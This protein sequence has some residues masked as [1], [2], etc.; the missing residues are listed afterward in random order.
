MGA[1]KSNEDGRFRPLAIE[2][3]DIVI[4]L[5]K[6]TS[7]VGNIKLGI[8]LKGQRILSSV[9]GDESVS[10]LDEL[11][12]VSHVMLGI[13]DGLIIHADGKSVA[14]ETIHDALKVNA[15]DAYLYHIY[16]HKKITAELG[17]RI[18]KA[19]KRYYGQAYSFFTYLGKEEQVDYTQFCSRLVAYA[20]RTEGMPLS[21]LADNKVLPL[22]LDRIC[23]TE[24]WQ[25]V[26]EKFIQKPLSAEAEMWL[27][28]IT[29]DLKLPS[30]AP[31]PS[32]RIF[33]E[34][35][36]LVLEIT[37]KLKHLQDLD[38][39]SHIRAVHQEFLLCELCM[40]EKT[41][42]EQ[43]RDAPG[44]IDDAYAD[45]ISNVLSQIEALLNIAQ[46]TSVELLVAPS[47]INEI[48]YGEDPVS[49]YVGLP[50]PADIH[51]MQTARET[52]T[53]HTFFVMAE[54]GL[55]CLLW[56]LTRHDRFEAYHAVK[57]E[58]ATN[59]QSA[60]QPVADLARYEAMADTFAWVDD[61]AHRE[62]FELKFRHVIAVLKL[63]E[64]L[65]RVKV[66]R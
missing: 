19:A 43:M 7:L 22:D 2:A 52:I 13:G 36:Q 47:P 33:E 11:P 40:A 48:A 39:R 1:Q 58:Y 31:V 55:C 9:R 6:P 14:E 29:G 56:H 44:D 65:P 38:Y 51:S 16:R 32:D 61:P 28:D 54:L 12:P 59:F 24:D 18:G 66:I 63:L 57:P 5:G 60:L 23:R 50:T 53:L 4:V 45:R 49:A 62:S 41:Q 64:L 42:A 3:G 10:L 25:D 35:D 26:T 20:Y 17:Q 21:K 37:Q 30:G 34:S 8:N 15:P 46:L 27:K